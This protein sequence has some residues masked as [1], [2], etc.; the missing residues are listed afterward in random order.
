MDHIVVTKPN[1]MPASERTKSELSMNRE[2]LGLRWNYFQDNMRES[3]GELR[4]VLRENKLA[5]LV[6]R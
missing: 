2:R 3:F 1:Q 4:D 6:L 5:S